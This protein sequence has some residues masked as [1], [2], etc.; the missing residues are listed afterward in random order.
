[1]QIP[2]ILFRFVALEPLNVCY[3]TEN[4]CLCQALF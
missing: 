1:M 3:Y 4:V 2:N